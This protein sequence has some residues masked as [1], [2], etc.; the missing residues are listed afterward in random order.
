MLGKGRVIQCLLNELTKAKRSVTI[1]VMF[2]R[3][4][5]FC[6]LCAALISQEIPQEQ[7]DKW[8][9]ITAYRRSSEGDLHLGPNG[10]PLRYFRLYNRETG[11]IYQEISQ[12]AA[13]FKCLTLVGISP[14]YTIGNMLVQYGKVLTDIGC[15]SYNTLYDLQENWD[16]ESLLS[17]LRKNGLDLSTRLGRDV[18]ELISSPYYGVAIFLCALKGMISNPYEAM[19]WIGWFESFWHW[20]KPAKRHDLLRHF[21]YVAAEGSDWTIYLAYCMQKVGHIDDLTETG[22]PVWEIIEYRTNNERTAMFEDLL[23]KQLPLIQ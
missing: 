10:R 19:S 6:S 5:F 1:G 22:E 7:K 15:V 12:E 23:C 2:G 8:S 3:I 11:D 16:E 17:I 9:F 13:A 21:D 20:G 14:L 4:L 18:Y